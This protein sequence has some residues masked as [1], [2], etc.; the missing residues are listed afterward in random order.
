MTHKS[1]NKLWAFGPLISILLL[2]AAYY[3]KVP[4]FRDAVNSRFPWAKDH[5]SQFVPPPTVV[6]IQDS[7]KP[8][9]PIPPAE[10][11]RPQTVIATTPNPMTPV[12]D[13]KGRDQRI[14]M[15]DCVAD[16]SLWPKSVRLLRS[17]EFPAVLDGK[18]IGKIRA[19]AGTDARLVVVKDHQVGVEFR[20][21]GAWV[22]I[23][24]TDLMEKAKLTTR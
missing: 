1:P 7:P 2:M 3:W 16:R 22:S 15:Q 11:P 4:A 9:R 20:G 8:P 13:T 12:P 24:D 18:V 14:A 6:V 23:D 5:L 17:I 19:P 21:G 10:S